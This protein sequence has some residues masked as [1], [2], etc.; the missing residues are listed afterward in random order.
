MLAIAALLLRVAIAFL[1]VR[2]A[3]LEAIRQVLR[4]EPELVGRVMLRLLKTA[5]FREEL[6]GLIVEAL[7]SAQAGGGEEARE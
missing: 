7:A 2:W 1:I 4:H 3:A 5:R 6:K